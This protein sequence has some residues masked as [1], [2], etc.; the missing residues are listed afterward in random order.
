MRGGS[1]ALL[2]APAR[3]LHDI[4]NDVTVQAFLRPDGNA[5]SARARAA[6]GHAGRELSA[7]RP[8][9][10]DLA[11]VDAALHDAA[12]LWIADFVELYEGETRLADPRS[13]PRGCRCPPIAP[14]PTTTRRCANSRARRCRPTRSSTGA[15]AMLDVLARVPDSLGP[16]AL[17]DPPGAGAAGPARASR[18]CGSCRRAAP[19]APSSSTATPASSG[20]IRAGIRRRCASSKLGF[21]HILD[22]TDHLLFLLCLVIPFRRF[23]PL[24]AVVTAFTVA[25]SITLIA[26]A[27]DLAPTALW[28]PPLIETLIAASIVYMALENIVGAAAGAALARDVRIRPRARLRL[29]VRAARDAAV[30]R[31]RTS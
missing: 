21:F 1:V 7:P 8:G 27:F 5:A 23:R 11:R 31:D 4:P 18:C 9:A 3:P 13:P 15:R 16:V 6:R 14:S 30:R 22:G 26:S 19:C 25:H 20:S 28:F 24:V 10:L 12:R 29:L 2:G 17:L